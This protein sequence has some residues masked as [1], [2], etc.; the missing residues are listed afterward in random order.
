MAN[1]Y[2]PVNVFEVWSTIRC[3][4]FF[5]VPTVQ[6][7]PRS[8]LPSGYGSSFGAGAS[9]EHGKRARETSGRYGRSIVAEPSFQ[10]YKT[11]TTQ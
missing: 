3:L 9:V 5:S 1:D 8:K 11:G 4:L 2:F 6:D 7:T 10:S